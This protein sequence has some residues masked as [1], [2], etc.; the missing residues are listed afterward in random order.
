MKKI[1]ICLMLA[2][3]LCCA[4]IACDGGE[5]VGEQTSAATGAISDAETEKGEDSL[6][7]SSVETS[8]EASDTESADATVEETYVSDVETE[9]ET[10][11]E[12]GPAKEKNT[13]ADDGF[14]SETEDKRM[15][16]DYAPV[17]ILGAKDIYDLTADGVYEQ[18]ASL[19]KGY[20]EVTYHVEDGRAYT[21]LLTYNDYGADKEAYITLF[22]EKTAV[23]PVIAI[24]Y[25]TKT[26]GVVMEM[27]TDSVNKTVSGSSKTSSSIVSDGN[28]QVA[29]INLKSKISA[30][31]GETANY[32]RFD[33]INS[34]SLPKDA[35][36]DIE[37]IAFFKTEKD[38]S[39]FEY[40]KV[41]EIVYID[42]ASGYKETSLVHNT[43]LDMINGKGEG[44][45]KTYDSRG[46]NS[47]DGIET[48]VFNG[49]TFAECKLVFSGW[50]VVDGGVEKF[51]WSADGGKTWHD[52]EFFNAS[53][54]GNVGDPHINATLKETGAA[55]LNDP[56]GAKVKTA[57]QGN[58]SAA[59]PID[60][61][62][63]IAADLS[64]FEGK[65]VNVILAAVP[66]AEKDSLA[67]IAY[68]VGVQVTA[69]EEG[70]EG[71]E[72]LDPKVDP[73]DC[74]AHKESKKWYPVIGEA[75]ESKRCL[76]CGAVIESTLRNTMFVV[77]SD[78]IEFTEGARGW[79]KTYAG[80]S[81]YVV[82]DI[83]AATTTNLGLK[84]SGWV[85]VN[86]GVA[87][88]KWSVDGE[89]WFDVDATSGYG[90]GGA[91]HV[92]SVNS[93]E[94]GI[95]N[96]TSKLQYGMSVSKLNDMGAG[97]YTVMIGVEP[98]NNPGVVICVMTIKN[99]T[100][101]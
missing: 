88:Y 19:F 76:D 40:G 15:E 90:S 91:A 48:F 31:N 29:V 61:A 69:E 13:E 21:K 89:N 62:K 30:Y 95:E 34:S 4:L 8:A 93:F 60:R 10:Y 52:T 32:F 36:L 101:K 27:Y 77:C 7:E 26:P 96:F 24:K 12:Y 57:Y 80:D 49:K 20:D 73:A 72:V 68:V 45:A 37:Y 17:F 66:K 38:A 81:P 64:E 46:G 70:A 22:N 87:S 43:Y 78:K 83:A 1:L 99:I 75:K 6:T 71:E 9:L 11:T 41:E 82:D 50:T 56:E 53:G 39:L 79:K 67:L 55:K 85:A 97:T 18:S 23:A 54:L 14:E 86:G 100:V 58:A 2:A 5:S 74:K 59:K 42:P 98:V 16:E 47:L 94:L 44:D 51:V 28:W 25:R 3:V 33:Y 92:S 65:T 63:G 84:L 35:Y